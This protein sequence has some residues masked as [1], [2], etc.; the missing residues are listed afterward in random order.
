M[1]RQ[2]LYARA[3]QRVDEMMAAGFLDEVR[4]LLTMGYRRELPS[5]S[6]L[7]YA[8]L[9]SH[10]FGE[11]S[12]EAAVTDTKMATHHFIRQQ[13]TWF[14]GH[15]KGILWHNSEALVP[16]DLIEQTRHWLEGLT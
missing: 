6:G 13:Y 1:D 12:L 5:M 11:I 10:L 2:R 8:Q 7:G 3:D 4:R 14:R 15:D 16:S 9:A